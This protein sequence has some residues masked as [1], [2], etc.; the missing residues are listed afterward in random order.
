MKTTNE[1]MGSVYKKGLFREYTDATF[2]TPKPHPPE[3]GIL[4]PT[5]RAEVGDKIVVHFKNRLLFNASV[6]LWGG[7]APIGKT[8]EYQVGLGWVDFEG[9][10]LLWL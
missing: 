7:L 1:T 6:Q 4:G 2:K 3:N 8:T 5:I 10:L 9:G